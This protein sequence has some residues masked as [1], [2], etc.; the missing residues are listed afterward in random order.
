MKDLDHINKI[1]ALEP[2]KEIHG[3]AGLVGEAGVDG[4]RYGA[5]RS[6]MSEK[7]MVSGWKWCRVQ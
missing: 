5:G 7:Q 2:G 6:V 1:G 3:A 4:R